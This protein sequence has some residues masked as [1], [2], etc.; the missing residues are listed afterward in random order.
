MRAVRVGLGLTPWSGRLQ[1][2]VR[3]RVMVCF[4]IWV[5]CSF[6]G[7]GPGLVEAARTAAPSDTRPQRLLLG[8]VAAVPGK[9][10]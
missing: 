8:T 6:K 3:D 9:R 1:V 7:L 10:I 5:R 4:R 2:A